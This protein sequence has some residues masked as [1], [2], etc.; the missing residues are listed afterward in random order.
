MCLCVYIPEKVGLA[1]VNKNWKLLHFW[2]H[3]LQT[4]EEYE[5]RVIILDNLLFKIHSYVGGLICF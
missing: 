4:A 1:S 5:Q 3:S 2:C